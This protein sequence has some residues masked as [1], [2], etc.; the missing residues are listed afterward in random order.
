MCQY[1]EK[2]Q[3][4][5]RILQG[6][7]CAL[8]ISILNTV[9]KDD[10]VMNKKNILNTYWQREQI[11]PIRSRWKAGSIIITSGQFIHPLSFNGHLSGSQV[12]PTF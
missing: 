6:Q 5:V 12:F 8:A 2:K 4:D 1:S 10:T 3:K 7:E 9:L 11:Q